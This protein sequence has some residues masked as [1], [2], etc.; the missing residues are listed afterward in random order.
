MHILNVNIIKMILHYLKRSFF[1]S[2]VIL[3]ISCSGGKAVVEDATKILPPA[4]LYGELFYDVQKSNIFEDSKTFVDAIPIWNVDSITHRYSKRRNLVDGELRNFVFDNFELP[5]TKEK[6]RSD[7]LSIKQHITSLWKVLERPLDIKHS[8][9]LIPLPNPYIVPGGRFREIYYWDSYFTMLGLKE[10]GQIETIQNMVDNFSYLI[11][12]YGFIPNGNRTYY[13]GRSQPSFYAMMIKV[14]AE[15]KGEETYVKYLPY[16]EKEYNFWMDGEATL[17]S[18]NPTKRRVVLLEDGEVLNR[19]WDDNNSPRPESY[20]EDVRTAGKALQDFPELSREDIYRNLRAGAESGWDFSSRWLVKNIEG[21]YDLSTIR[22]THIIP[23]DL[24]VLL[25]NMERTLSKAFSLKGNLAKANVYKAKYL[26]RKKTIN[27]YLWNEKEGFFKD[28]NFVS[29]EQTET[30]SLAGVY[31]LFFDLA[32][33][34]QARSVSEKIEKVFL[35]PGG[36]VTTIN[37]TGQQWDAPN[38]WAPLQYISIQGLRN[39]GFNDLAS[40]ISQRWLS[41]N[42]KVYQQ[43]F[44][45]LEKY[46]V[47]DLSKESGGGEY[48]TQD[49]FGWTNGVFQ[50]LSQD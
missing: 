40:K 1:T 39:Y 13:L 6:Y 31:P 17:N 27:K 25:F 7:S 37:N 30:I 15:I 46:N 2:L 3:F 32:N 14:L 41:L 4:D 10:D 45:M 38:G 35:R 43:S 24:N 11:D 5:Q 9:T 22:T 48:P 36:L 8:G 23:I 16:L 44:K 50:K 47:E 20:K 26:A 29:G 34:K 33:D 18:L 19:Y 42:Q 49:G 28:Y 12:T 21:N